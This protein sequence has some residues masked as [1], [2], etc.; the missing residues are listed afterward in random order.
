MDIL[1]MLR[2]LHRHSFSLQKKKLKLILKVD[3]IYSYCL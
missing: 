3:F 1:L 2:K